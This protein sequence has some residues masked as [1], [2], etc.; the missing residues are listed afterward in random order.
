[1]R[2][3]RGGGGEGS[4][5]DSSLLL[6]FFWGVEWVKNGGTRGFYEPFITK[7]NDL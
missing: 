3:G 4:R 1:M 7:S 2:R 6:T 5:C